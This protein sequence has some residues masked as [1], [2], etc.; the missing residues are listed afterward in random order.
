MRVSG[1]NAAFV[2]VRQEAPIVGERP[3]L[4]DKALRP[5]LAGS[6]SSQRCPLAA[7][8][9][10]SLA[11]PRAVFGDP[12]ESRLAA[13]S[14]HI[15]KS[16]KADARLR[17]RQNRADRGEEERIFTDFAGSGGRWRIASTPIRSASG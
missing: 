8:R 9:V 2:Y 1:R 15:A 13:K 4:V 6:V 10:R 16:Q 14:R 17:C 5:L 3:L 12:W 7:V 11:T